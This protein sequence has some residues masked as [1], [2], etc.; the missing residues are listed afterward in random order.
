MRTVIRSYARI[1]RPTPRRSRALPARDAHAAAVTVLAARGAVL[2]VGGEGNAHGVSR[3]SYIS[4]QLTCSD[5]TDTLADEWVR[6]LWCSAE[7]PQAK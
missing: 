2:A 6:L 3:F 4:S 7:P 1:A 5:G